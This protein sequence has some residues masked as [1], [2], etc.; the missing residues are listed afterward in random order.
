MCDVAYAAPPV[1]PEAVDPPAEPGIRWKVGPTGRLNDADVPTE[2]HRVSLGE[3][4]KITTRYGVRAGA[5]QLGFTVLR[6]SAANGFKATIY[7][8]AG[9]DEE[10]TLDHERWHAR[11]FIHD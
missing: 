8:V 10:A 11:G 5:S 2:V 3:M 6:G 7:V 4:R 1:L 9:R